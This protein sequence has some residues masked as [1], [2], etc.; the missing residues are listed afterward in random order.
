MSITTLPK[1]IHRCANCQYW[2]GPREIML[3]KTQVKF[4]T[5]AYGQCGY[6]RVSKR[7]DCYCQRHVVISV[8]K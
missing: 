4:D 1:S 6:W 2:M 8:Y 5:N 7:A 3:G